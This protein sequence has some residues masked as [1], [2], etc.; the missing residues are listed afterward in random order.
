MAWTE[1]D[2]EG[3]ASRVLAAY[4]AND[5]WRAPHDLGAGEIGDVV[6]AD[7]GAATV[8]WTEPGDSYGSAARVAR[9]VDGQ[10]G[11]GEVVAGDAASPELTVNRR[12]DLALVA[13]TIQGVSVALRPRASGR[14]G[15]PTSLR[16]IPYSEN[17]HIGIDDRGRALVIWARSPEEEN[18]VRKHIAWA[19]TKN[20]G[21]W[22]TV[23]Y[24]DLRTHKEVVGD[25]LGFSM[26]P[27]GEAVAAW[28]PDSLDEGGF[29]VARFTF[30]DGW[31]SPRRLADFAYEPTALLTDSGSAVV[32]LNFADQPDW[33]YQHPGADWTPGGRLVSNNPLDA[34]GDGQQMAVLYR[35]GPHLTA[36]FLDVKP[37]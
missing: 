6:I 28:S 18:V 23:Q 8:A 13:A 11:P 34:Y 37:R 26:N 32:T 36:R 10:W 15:P 35:A 7:D 5:R 14:W 25:E 12:G 9:L 29:K 31:T 16:G 30:R 21:T 19:R 4:R 3:A 2:A 24:L 27:R 17:P 1:N 22:S 20:D 33:V